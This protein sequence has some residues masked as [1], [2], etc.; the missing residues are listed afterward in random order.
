MK[1]LLA[2]IGALAVLV[3]LV[4]S[5]R[6]GVPQEGNLYMSGN[7]LSNTSV[8][9]STYSTNGQIGLTATVAPVT[10]TIGGASVSCRTC[11][12]KFVMQIE[13]MTIVNILDGATTDYVIY[14]AG[15]TSP[16]SNGG[17]STLV[18][19]EDHLGPFCLGAGDSFTVNFQ[20]YGS[21]AGAPSAMSGT[22]LLGNPQSFNWEGY[23]QCGGNYNAGIMK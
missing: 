2:G 20:G 22:G 11:F 23:T 1:K 7:N 16:T 4:G 15:I 17:S 19:G 9:G 10:S 5:A 14:G 6:A 3:C 12:T 13:T 8:I 18:L 21:A